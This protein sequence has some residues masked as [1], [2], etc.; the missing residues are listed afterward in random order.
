MAGFAVM[1]AIPIST[2]QFAPQWIEQSRQQ[3]E[4]MDG[5]R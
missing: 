3:L 2:P 5:F 4:I 1:G